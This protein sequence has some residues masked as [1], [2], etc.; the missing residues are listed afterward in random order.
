MNKIMFAVYAV[1]GF[2]AGSFIGM[3]NFAGLSGAILPGLIAGVVI[4]IPCLRN[5]SWRLAGLLVACSLVGSI[6]STTLPDSSQIKSFCREQSNL[7]IKMGSFH[8][9]TDLQSK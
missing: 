6:V 2:V 1:F 7:V 5:R 8:L 4:A 3:G 9:G